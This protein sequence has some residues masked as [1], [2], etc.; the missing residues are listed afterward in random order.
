MNLNSQSCDLLAAS[1]ADAETLGISHLTIGKANVV[2]FGVHSVGCTEAG[3]QLARVASGGLAEVNQVPHPDPQIDLPAISFSSPNPLNA[4]MAAQYA[5]WPFQHEDYF[6]MGS[7]PIRLLRGKEKI[8]SQYG[9]AE[10]SGQGAICLESSKLPCVAQVNALASEANLQADRLWIAVASTR[11]LAGS[12]QVVARSLETAMHKLHEI[13]FDISQIQSGQGFAPVPPTAHEDLKAIGLTNDSILFG[14]QV[15]LFVDV[16]PQVIEELGP[17]TPSSS[18]VDFGKPFYELF[19]E[20]D[21]NFYQIDP[22]LFSPAKIIFHN[23]R[24]GKSSTFGAIH[25]DLLKA[26]FESGTR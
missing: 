8:L 4:C 6:A 19:R 26:S 15:E 20:N 10:S 5:G 7:G 11:S 21:F 13:G 3:L 17:R 16:E 2:D 1:A 23:S 25:P 22:L 9:L 12:L 24:S 18:S 14:G